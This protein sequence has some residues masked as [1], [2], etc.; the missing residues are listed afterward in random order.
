M[1]EPEYKPIDH[2]LWPIVSRRACYAIVLTTLLLGSTVATSF[3]F[4]H[5]TLLANVGIVLIWGVLVTIVMFCS[6]S[7]WDA[8]QTWRDHHRT[9][10]VLSI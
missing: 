2:V 10:H 8:W 5:M 7:R 6:W 9:E 3:I 1:I 4:S